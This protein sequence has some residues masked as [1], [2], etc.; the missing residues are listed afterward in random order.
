MNK[1]VCTSLLAACAF[2]SASAQDLNCLT[3]EQKNTATLYR[4]LQQQAYAALDRRLET[5]EQLKTPEQIRAH[6]EKLRQ[7]FIKQLG[8]F[9][10][11]TPLNAKT[12]GTI[13]ADG[14]RIEKVIF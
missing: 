5:Y 7:F 2:V 6:Q 10:Q 8:G 13:E 9:P 11:R 1:L 3:D 14:Y 4:D 12:V